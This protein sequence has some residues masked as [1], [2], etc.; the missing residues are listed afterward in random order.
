[1]T[2]A[3]PTVTGVG[4]RGRRI[5]LTGATGMVGGPLARALARDNTVHGAA[6]FTSPAAR[7]ALEQSGVLPVRVDLGTADFTDVPSDVELVLNFAVARS[8]DWD[9]DFAVNVD[10]VALLMEHC[11]ARC[12]GLQAFF[13]CSTAGVYQS[14]G[15]VPLDESAPLGDSHRAAGFETYSLS[16]IAAESLVRHTA[17][18]LGLPTVVARLSVPYGETFGWPFFQLMMIERGIPLHVHPDAPSHYSPLHLDDIVASLPVLLGAAS[19]P[20]TVV[21]WG[22]DET[23]SV[24]EWCGYLAELVG[25]EAI[26]RVDP[27]AIPPLPLDLARLHALGSHSSV[28]W[29]VGI[30][31]LVAASG[32][33]AVQ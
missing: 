4:L 12:D 18:R 7:D 9:A 16:K 11:A 24:E 13:H 30:R 27:N 25:A 19:T 2:G 26:F 31:R 14:Q 5:L 22:G 21:N 32:R 1:V 8:N 6:R 15:H 29:R 33:V 3:D 28:D 20:A 23:V 10:G 17:A